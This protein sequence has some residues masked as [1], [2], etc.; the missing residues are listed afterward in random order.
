MTTPLTP[1]PDTTAQTLLL[2]E[3][4]RRLRLPVLLARYPKVAQEAARAQSQ[5]RRLPPGLAR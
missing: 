2:E 4:L 5:L 1:G 3:Y